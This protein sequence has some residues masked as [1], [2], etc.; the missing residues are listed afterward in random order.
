MH[1]WVNIHLRLAKCSTFIERHA[2]AVHQARII[3]FFLTVIIVV[4][5]TRLIVTFAN[6]FIQ[7]MWFLDLKI[8]K[9][10]QNI[11]FKLSEKIWKITQPYFGEGRE[12]DCE[13]PQAR[14]EPETSTWAPQH[15]ISEAHAP[16]TAP[17]LRPVL[18]S[19]KR[20]TRDTVWSVYTALWC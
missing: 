20:T 2:R 4:F 14:I 18:H 10:K 19:W 16:T 8:I 15:N 11:K 12:W 6:T 1:F 3:F 9:L 17:W 13:M 5:S 7:K